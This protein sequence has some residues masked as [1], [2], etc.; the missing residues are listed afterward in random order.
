MRGDEKA[1][2]QVK[3]KARR[4]YATDEEEEEEEEAV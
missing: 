2:R 3:R 4:E 1:G